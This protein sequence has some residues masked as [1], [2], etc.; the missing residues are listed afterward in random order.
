MAKYPPIHEKPDYSYT[1]DR[2]EML[3]DRYPRYH[4]MTTFTTL[5]DLLEE[6]ESYREDFDDIRE[7]YLSNGY[8][9]FL[10]RLSWADLPYRYETKRL[11]EDSVQPSGNPYVEAFMEQF[12]D[13]DTDYKACFLFPESFV[14]QFF[15]IRKFVRGRM[16][17][18]RSVTS[19]R[20]KRRCIIWQYL[21]KRI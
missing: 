12:A 20:T 16:I 21:I 7:E 18:A 17:S 6:H 2:L 1:F 19:F 5:E 14:S 13:I 10:V 8:D 9:R 4:E 3:W 15:V 11:I